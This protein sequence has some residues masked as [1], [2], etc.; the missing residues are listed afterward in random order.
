MYTVFPSSLRI[1]SVEKK[2]KKPSETLFKAAAQAAEAKGIDPGEVLHV[3]SNVNRDI[4]P[5]KKIGFK[6]ALFAGDKSS[7]SA[8]PE[9]LKDSASR[10]DVLLTELT[11]IL[12]VIG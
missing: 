3:G 8:T 1:I 4:V 6:T 11:Q 12:E 9:Q 7:L 5:A 10:P 2:A